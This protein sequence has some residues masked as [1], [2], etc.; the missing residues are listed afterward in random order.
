MTSTVNEKGQL[1]LSPEVTARLGLKPGDQ[2]TVETGNGQCV[3][4]PADVGLRWEGNVL[5]H[6]GVGV[7]PSVSELRD[8]H[9]AR[10]GEGTPA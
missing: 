10:L 3:L 5:V 4:R 2:V 7:G 6:Q 1:E 8:E 9:F